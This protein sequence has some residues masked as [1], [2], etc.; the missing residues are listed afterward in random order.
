MLIGKDT[1]IG[2]ILKELAER[3]LVSLRESYSKMGERIRALES[4]LNGSES[5]IPSVEP[6]TKSRKLFG[7]TVSAEEAADLALRM[8]RAE[9][10]LKGRDAMRVAA[11]YK[12]FQERNWEIKG[13]NP[14]ESLWQTLLRKKE[15][16]EK[17]GDGLFKLVG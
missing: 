15:K 8:E 3:E 5:P 7:K 9:Q 4:Y 16:F 14:K 10:I 13:K 12:V 17:V 6:E 11:I 2:Q 1:D